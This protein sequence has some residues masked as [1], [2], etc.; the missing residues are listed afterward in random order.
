MRTLL[1]TG[2]AGFI[3]STFVGHIFRTYHD[4]RIIVLDALTYAGNPSNIPDEIK[5]SDRFEFWYGDVTNDSLVDTL[6]AKSDVV[7]H[8]AAESHVARSIFDNKVFYVTDVLG[9]QS[10]A[11]AIVKNRHVERF[12]HIST[13]EVYGTA[14]TEPM[15]EEHPLNPTTPYASAK[16]GADR[17]VYSYCRTYEIPAVILRLFNQYGPYQHLEKAIP[18]FIASAISNEELTVHGTGEVRR[19]WFHVHD[20]C[21]R[22]DR[23]LHADLDTVRGEVINIGSGLSCDILSIARTI[24]RLTGKSEKLIAFT[25]DRF[26]Q[27]QNH[28]SSTDKAERLLGIYPGRSFED[29][30]KDTISWYVR[31]EQWWQPLMWMRHVP[32]VG[33]GG[34]TEYY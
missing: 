32:I 20:T 21:E 33:K 34:K 23:A 24:V 6:V 8:F 27:V 3:G 13:S 17:L 31:N 10:V 22:I 9:T 29:G 26:G 2:G 4:Y 15:T 1:V 14:L 28:L 30:L 5:K 11:N 7:I 25:S 12:V 16:A 18:R 19:D